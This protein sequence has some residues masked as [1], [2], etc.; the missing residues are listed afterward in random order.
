M[1]GKNFVHLHLHT[2]YSLLDGACK[3]DRLAARCAKLGMP[4][5]AMTDHGNLFGAIDFYKAMTDA[6]IKPL[7][8]CEIYLVHDHAMHERPKVERK[9]SDDID[10]IPEEELGPDQ[11]PKYQ[12]HHKTL[13][14]KDFEGYRNLVKLVSDAHVNGFYRRP[15]TDMEKLAKYSKGLIGLSGCINGVA[16]QYLLYN[17]YARAREVIG[18]FVDIFGRDHYFIEIHDHGIGAQRRIIPGL[19]KLAGE[20]GLRVVA[21]NDV[22]YVDKDDWRPHDALLCI[23][24]GK[25]IADSDRMRYPSHQFYLK[26]REEMEAV[27]KEIPECLDNTLEVAAM[28]DLKI[29]FKEN[30]YPVFEIPPDLS[31]TPDE[32][33]F[34]SII[35]IYLEEKAK[36]D[37]RNGTEPTVLDAAKRAK[38]RRKGVVLFDLCKKGLKDRYQVDYDNPEAFVPGPGQ[39]AEFAEMV[40]RKLDYEMAIIAG[41]GFVDYFL[42]VWDFIDWARRRGI[43]VGP[44]RGSGAGCMVAYVLKITDIEPLRF[45]LL[46]E[47][48][49]NLERVSPPDFDIDF[50]MRRRDEV[51]EYVREKYGRDAVANIVTYGTFGAKMIVRDLARVN[52]VPYGEADKIAKMVPDDLNISLDDAVRKSPDLQR[53]VRDNPV[54]ADIIEQGKVIEG[55]VRNTGKHACGIII[56]DQPLTD[57]VPVTLQEGDLT[58]QYAKGPVEKLGLLKMDF[59]G[60]KNLTVISDAEANVRLTRSLPEFDIEKVTLGDAKT[61]DL[62]NRGQ[63]VGVFQLESSGMQNLCRQIGLSSFEEIIALIALYRPGPMQFIPQFIEGK[64]DPA[65]IQIPHPLIEDLVKE[66]Y[67]VLVYQEQVMQAAQ[68]V[69]GYT[70]GGADILRRAMGKKIKEV[71]A[72]QKEIFIRG[73]KE[74]NDINRKTAEEIFGILEKF[75]E[76]GFNKSHSAAYAMLSYRTA[77]LKANYPV[78]FMAA[79]LSSELTKA[80]KVAHFI[81]ECLEMGI[82][83]LGPSVNESRHAFTPVVEGADIEAGRIGSIRFGLSAIKGVGESATAS[84][85]EERD[86]RGPFRSFRDFVNRVDLKQVSRR[87]LECLVRSGAFDDLGEERAQLLAN[88]DTLVGSVASAQR[89]RES[90]QSSLFDLLG[91]GGD[92]GDEDNGADG[93]ILKEVPPMPKSERLEHEKELIG[94]YLTGHPMERF[95]LLAEAVDSFGYEDFEKLADRT[96]FRVCG[97]VS[98]V[99]K[100]FTRKDSKAWSRFQVVTRRHT[101]AVIAFPEAF[102]RVKGLIEDG[103]AVAVEGFLS[104]RDGERS[105]RVEQMEGLESYIRRAVERVGFLIRPDAEGLKLL[106]DLRETILNESGETEVSI[107]FP[108]ADGKAIRSRMAQSLRW[109]IRADSFQ[110]IRTAGPVIGCRILTRPLELEES[111]PRW[112]RG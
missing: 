102:E 98:G 2:D 44:G 74:H 95:E 49:L 111:Q 57:L 46:F 106:K 5:V 77:Y 42:I 65:R 70:L 87:V 9:R 109:G 78:E 94:F 99:Q 81:D 60:L 41:T 47:R 43:P 20:F 84:I 108:T 8:G 53:E 83:V 48:M 92:G 39:T 29:S 33:R 7:I 72:E 79:V 6:G 103:L 86:G 31:F 73:A 32:A 97:I 93:I 3:V 37:R 14:A 54:A 16:S 52:S 55:M 17:N 68:I 110:R 58:T 10:D 112:A 89:D 51:V 12:I 63:T 76:Y 25:F 19:L 69:A 85:L 30:H 100:L 96:P 4:A 11:M 62:L 15:R 64:R 59:L 56:A 107:S 40:C 88:L 75:A 21:A 101:Y 104:V 91:G 36:V 1:A 27:F 45:G 82:P 35:D 34:D 22:H 90:G 67:G 18:E 28:V 80:E 50:C 71:M 66:T 61:F 38:I 13:I 105:L 24:T 23:Q 26:S